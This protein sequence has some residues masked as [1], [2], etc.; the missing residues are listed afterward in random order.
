MKT[1]TVT[2]RIPG[3]MLAGMLAWGVAQGQADK[4]NILVI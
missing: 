1:L 3:I 4:P 2:I